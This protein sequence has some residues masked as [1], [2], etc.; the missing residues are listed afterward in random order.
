[1]QLWTSVTDI[2]CL[3]DTAHTLAAIFKQEVQTTMLK[4]LKA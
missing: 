4:L 1:M 3:P 2:F